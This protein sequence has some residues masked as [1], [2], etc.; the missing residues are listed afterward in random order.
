M[1]TKTDT[2]DIPAIAEHFNKNIKDLIIILNESIPQD[3]FFNSVKKKI[4]MVMDMHPLL[5]LEKGGMHIF[6]YRDYIKEN[7][8][9]ELFL[10]TDNIIKDSDKNEIEQEMSK[11][12]K[13]SKKNIENLIEIVRNAWKNYTKIEK[14]IV[15]DKFKRLLSD[16]CKYLRAK[17]NWQS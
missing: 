11:I 12:D 17:E 14:K 4:K 1:T 8:L 9:D 7:N 15:S 13:E 5:P 10:N 2:N 6:K 16:Y 3:L